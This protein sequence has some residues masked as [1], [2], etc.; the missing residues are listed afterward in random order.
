[1]VIGAC[2][3]IG[4]HSTD[5]ENHGCRGI[6]ELPRPGSDHRVDIDPA[7]PIR[8]PSQQPGQ[9][10]APGSGIE[11]TTET[12]GELP[13]N[14]PVV[15]GVVVPRIGGVE[16]VKHSVQPPQQSSHAPSTPNSSTVVYLD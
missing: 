16:L 14:P 13:Q 5:R 4:E 11:S 12:R 6:G 3:G 10:T 7:Q 1:H 15:V 9:V 8:T 2:G